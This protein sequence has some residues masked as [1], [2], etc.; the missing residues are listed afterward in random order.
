MKQSTRTSRCLWQ[1]M[2]HP[3][4]SDDTCSTSRIVSTGPWHSWQSSPALTCIMCGKWTWSGRS[5]R[6]STRL[7]S[8][9]V[10]NSYAVFCL[11][12]KKTHT[13]SF[14]S[15]ILKKS[16]RRQ[17]I[18]TI[19]CKLRLQLILNTL[20]LGKVDQCKISK[21]CINSFHEYK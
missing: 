2:H 6:K 4:W 1:S 14:R 13:I 19:Y 11:K 20:M 17:T 9:H 5:D 12:K 16:L 21:L 7:N 15:N 18:K 8:S 10:K 3:I